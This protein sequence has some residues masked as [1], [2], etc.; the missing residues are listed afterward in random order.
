VLLLQAVEMDV[1]G[2]VWA[3]GEEVQL[4]LEQE[5]VRA[6]IDELLALH[7]LLDDLA[8]LLVEERLTAGDRDHGRAAFLG[9][10]HA[11]RHREAAVQDMVRVI[12][13]TAARAGQVAPEQRLEHEHERVALAAHEALLHN[14]GADLDLLSNGNTHVPTS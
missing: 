11:V 1:E 14:V 9:R 10:L 3:R 13:L 12:D 8:D 2:Q 6:E 5:R 7:E 4:L